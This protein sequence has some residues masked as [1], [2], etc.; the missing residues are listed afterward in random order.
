M[1]VTPKLPR[2]IFIIPT[3]KIGGAELFLIRL[4]NM[5]NDRIEAFI[6]IMK[7]SHNDCSFLLSK[8]VHVYR[9]NL[10][11]S[12]NPI[13]N[14]ISIFRFRRFVIN[15]NPD[16]I[17]CFLYPAELL[18]ILLGRKYP[19][20]WSLRGSGSPKVK[21][22]LKRFLMSINI[23]FSKF[24]PLRIIACSSA[25]RRWAISRGI[26]KQKIEIVHNFVAEWTKST[27]SKSKLLDTNCNIAETGI[28][29]GMAAR[30]DPHKGHL[31]LRQGAEAFSKAT[32][33]PVTLCFAG[34]E[35]RRLASSTFD[36]GEKVL[37]EHKFKVEIREDISNPIELSKWFSSLD[38]YV[39]ASDNV[40]G[41]PNAL[42]EA[43]AIGCPT[44]ASESGNSGEMISEEFLLV[45][46]EPSTIAKAIS[47]LVDSSKFDL[48]RGIE[49]S[50]KKLKSITNED[51][52]CNAY[53]KIWFTSI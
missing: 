39:F 35:T 26:P 37:P 38:L 16:A 52:I 22:L 47:N 8:N 30:L 14:L 9:M 27:T 12:I 23:L 40:E 28:R 13:Q 4:I 21:N 2:I 34:R 36:V 50:Q 11:L 1:R 7:F 33:Y 31:N 15:L 41:F 20:Y 32:G 5:L 10:K 24:F 18:S 51:L 48:R 45:N 3:L 49:K 42:A 46:N 44:L 25:A 6:V 53:M 29:I 43:I 19:I 17:Q